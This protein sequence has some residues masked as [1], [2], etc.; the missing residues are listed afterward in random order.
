MKLQGIFF[1]LLTKCLNFIMYCAT[2]AAIWAEQQLVAI[3]GWLL[4][5]KCNARL[6]QEEHFAS[7]KEPRSPTTKE[8]E[9]KRRIP[10]CRGGGTRWRPKPFPPPTPVATFG[11]DPR[12]FR[13]TGGFSIPLAYYDQIRRLRVL[14][15]FMRIFPISANSL[16]H[17]I[18]QAREQGC[19]TDL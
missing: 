16:I 4:T 7:I 8:N 5:A 6:H 15:M 12:V 11:Q 2:D 19:P 9:A 17:S 1:Q 14:G 10:C 13:E 18:R 3:P